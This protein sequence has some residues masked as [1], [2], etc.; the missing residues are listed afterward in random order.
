M[1]DLFIV[2]EQESAKLR[3]RTRRGTQ[4]MMLGP[5]C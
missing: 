1:S 2:I 3:E 5:H 4:G